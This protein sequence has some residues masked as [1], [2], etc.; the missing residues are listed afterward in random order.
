MMGHGTGQQE[1]DVGVVPPRARRERSS[2]LTHAT[3][4]RVSLLGDFRLRVADQVVPCSWTAQ[5]VLACLAWRGSPLGRAALAATLWPDDDPQRSRARIRTVA[6]ELRHRTRTPLLGGDSESMWMMTGVRVDFHEAESVARRF[7]RGL[8]SRDPPGGVPTQE[9]ELLTQDVLER[10][11]CEWVLPVRETFRELR[12]QAMEHLC[13]WLMG[14]QEYA[15]ATETALRALV[16]E[17]FRES[18]HRALIEVHLAQGN[19]FDALRQYQRYCEAMADLGVSP[20][21]LIR[22]LIAPI[23]T[24]DP[25]QQFLL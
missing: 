3:S 17:P 4:V 19:T 7:V 6:W 22:R 5:Q 10:W 15:A 21:Q 18:I 1:Q 12:V 20:S 24:G 2:S 25:N 8:E 14:R 13:R 16:A 11:E 9:L 23:L